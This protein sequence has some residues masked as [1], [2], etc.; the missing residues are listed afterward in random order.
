[1]QTYIECT[2]GKKYHVDR[3]QV[4]R[5]ACEGCRRE[6]TV[7]GEALAA[8]LEQLR[9]RMKDGG[10]PGM[11]EAA[12]KAAELN[13]F[14]ALSILKEAAQS[15]VRDAVNTALV[16]LADFE[17]AGEDV[18]ADWVKT[19]ALSPMRLTAAFREKEYTRGAALICSMI[20]NGRLKEAQIAEV[21]P[22]LGDS[23][24]KR[25]LESLK[26]ARRAYPNLGGIL[27]DALARMKGLDDSAGEIPE[28]AKRIPGRSA[29]QP[30]APS[31][32][33]KK[34]C[35]GVLLLALAAPLLALAWWLI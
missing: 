13:D 17:G 15:G 29:G 33:G 3:R 11:R 27:D 32:G 24:S 4:E 19:G 6:L 23:G 7:P 2:C 16:G 30:A 12:K 34:G 14:H 22:Y 8:R 31:G 5:F 25:A 35:A 26:A 10:E 9:A 20:D 21:A 28:E 18:I 1:M